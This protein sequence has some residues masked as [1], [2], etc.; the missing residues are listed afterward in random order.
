MRIVGAILEKK[1]FMPH[2]YYSGNKSIHI[3]V[4]LDWESI[5]L[6][7]KF[8]R[9]GVSS[10]F[11]NS[12]DRFKSEFL[13]WLRELMISCWGTRARQFDED[14]IRATHLIRAELSKNKLGYKTFLGWSYLDVPPLPII[15]N[16]D[17][18]Q[19]PEIGAI[20]LSRPEDPEKLVSEFFLHLDTSAK[21]A[22]N[23][24]KVQPLE[25]F[26][27]R[28]PTKLRECVKFILSDEFKGAGDGMSRGMFILVNELKRSFGKDMALTILQDWNQRMG[29][30]IREGDIYYRLSLKE[31]T[32]SCDYI[33]RFLQ[34]IGIDASKKCQGKPY[35]A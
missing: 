29:N 28:R 17:N 18:G 1:G 27:P 11:N 15:C 19:Y 2:Y 31:Y 21:K 4:Y 16:E 33:H 5:L 24:R 22:H 9:T 26:S 7:G 13:R 30:T 23:T 20:Q 10:R 3:H 34:E 32:L 6:S 8:Q 12:T 14:L 25:G 35:K